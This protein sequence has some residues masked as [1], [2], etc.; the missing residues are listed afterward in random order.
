MTG[1]CGSS[2]RSTGAII[3]VVGLTGEIGVVGKLGPFSLAVVGPV[4]V[5]FPGSFP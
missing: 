1:D 3:G 2:F 4:E 5:I